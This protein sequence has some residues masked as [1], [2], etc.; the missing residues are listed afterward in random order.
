MKDHA[1]H[2]HCSPPE[3]YIGTVAALCEKLAL[4]LTPIRQRVLELIVAHGKP[5]KAYDLLSLLQ[6]ERS[7]AAPATVYRVLDFLIEHGF[8]HKLE[9]IN[10]YTTCLHPHEPHTVPFLICKRCENTTEL[11]D[12]DISDSLISQA[13]QLGFKPTAQTLEV[14]GLCRDCAKAS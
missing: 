5:I 1:A 12:A 13:R 2:R 3:D 7:G 14:H 8:I 4:R 9:S 10:A 11:C 6:K